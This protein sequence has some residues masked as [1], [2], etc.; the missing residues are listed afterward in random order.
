MFQKTVKIV[1]LIVLLNFFTNFDNF[2][3]KDGQDDI[4]M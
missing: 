1:F 4:I 2:G 3:H